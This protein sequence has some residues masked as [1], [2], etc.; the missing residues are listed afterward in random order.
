M[1]EVPVIE[2]FTT[3]R[4]VVVLAIDRE[5]S[6]ERRPERSA[7]PSELG[8]P[9]CADSSAQPRSVKARKE[10][11]CRRTEHEGRYATER[12]MQVRQPAQ[13]RRLAHRTQR[14]TVAR[15]LGKDA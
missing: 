7:D 5:I 11:L 6:F 8:A 10:A 15:F 3:S 2:H 4:Q 14:V 13:T 9:A 1:T 12:R